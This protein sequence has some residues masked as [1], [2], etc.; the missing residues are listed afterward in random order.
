MD[1]KMLIVFCIKWEVEMNLQ[2]FFFFFCY[3]LDKVTIRL[4]L[5]F[6]LNI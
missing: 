5:S 4:E 2:D 3:C 1:N 6:S